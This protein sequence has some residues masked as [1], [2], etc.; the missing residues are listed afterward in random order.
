MS[1]L[2]SLTWCGMPKDDKML[3]L[4]AEWCP[5]RLECIS[6]PCRQIQASFVS[7]NN[8]RVQQTESEMTE[9]KRKPL[10]VGDADVFAVDCILERRK[11]GKKVK[12]RSCLNWY[13]MIEFLVDAVLGEMVWISWFGKLMGGCTECNARSDQ[14]IHF[15]NERKTKANDRRFPRERWISYWIESKRWIVFRR[16]NTGIRLQYPVTTAY[17]TFSIVFS[18]VIHSF[19]TN[20]PLKWFQF[21]SPTTTNTDVSTKETR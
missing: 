21:Q 18:A 3:R 14:I 10:Y 20:T 16:R 13:W 2:A 1:Y 4:F 15:E 6:S 9:T 5:F 17:R 11:N 12:V 8:F 19:V 7:W